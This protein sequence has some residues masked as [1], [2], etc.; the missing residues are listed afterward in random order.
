MADLRKGILYGV[1]SEHFFGK[2]PKFVWCVTEEGLVYEAKTEA[3]MPGAYHGY[4]LEE[5]DDFREV[6]KEVWNKR[7]HKTG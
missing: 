3:R 7:W 4:P 2:Y 1:V 6:V 5:E